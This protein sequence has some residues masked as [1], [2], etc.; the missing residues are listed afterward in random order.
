MST[1]FTSLEISSCEIG[2]L[3]AESLIHDLRVNNF[4]FTNFPEVIVE[5][6]SENFYI[7]LQAH[8]QTTQAE[9]FPYKAM[10]TLIKD[11][12]NK[13]ERDKV[14]FTSIQNLAVQL[15]S[16]IGKARNA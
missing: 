5:W 3:V 9:S 16:L 10:K 15:E 6:D 1:Y 4:T 12:R 13:K 11:F 14:F 2:G 8:G 7:K